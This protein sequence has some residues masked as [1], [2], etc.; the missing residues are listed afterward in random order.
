MSATIERTFHLAPRSGRRGGWR[1]FARP[2]P[3][4]E[5]A[6]TTV[7]GIHPLTR[8]MAMAIT[9]QRL[10]RDGA[11]ADAASLAGTA[12]VTR[13]RMTQILNFTGL[14]PDIQAVL[15][16]LPDDTTIS[17]RDLRPIM[18]MLDWQRQRASW[19]RLSAPRS[20]RTQGE[21]NR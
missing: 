17:E 3:E 14:A 7:A 8:R 11:V 2:G 18:A 12:G 20:T 19:V 1:Q 4:V 5:L 13:A 9:C 15:L 6:E 16:E 10:I 21:A